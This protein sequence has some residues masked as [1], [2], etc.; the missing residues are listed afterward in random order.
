M[1]AM[2]IAHLEHRTGFTPVAH[3]LGDTFLDVVPIQSRDGE[4]SD[5]LLHVIAASLEEGREAVDNGVE[6]TLV[7]LA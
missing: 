1:G 6:A 5:F 3:F 4:E 7:P 2:R